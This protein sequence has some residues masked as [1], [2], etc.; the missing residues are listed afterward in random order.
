[1]Y[2][3]ASV[4]PRLSVRHHVLDLFVFFNSL[5]QW[6]LQSDNV[7]PKDELTPALGLVNF[8]KVSLTIRDINF[9]R[10][11]LNSKL[12]TLFTFFYF[13]LGKNTKKYIK[14]APFKL[15]KSGLNHSSLLLQ[16][17][18]LKSSRPMLS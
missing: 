16:K 5:F 4:A 1:M 3:A 14:S 18:R 12:P 7:D 17:K 15:K 9:D 11:D 10:I 13:D 8:N 6:R 2:P